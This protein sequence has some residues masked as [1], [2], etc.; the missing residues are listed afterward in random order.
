LVG[1]R[2]AGAKVDNTFFA[3]NG[4]GAHIKG[5][6]KMSGSNIRLGVEG[7]RH[8][9]RNKREKLRRVFAELDV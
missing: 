9:N 6:S 4:G 1:A 5:T 2:S 3:V 7:K 8:G